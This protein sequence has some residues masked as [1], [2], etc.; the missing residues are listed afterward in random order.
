MAATECRWDVKA[1]MVRPVG[2]S[3][4]A[5]SRD[6]ESR[7]FIASQRLTFERSTDGTSRFER[8]SVLPNGRLDSSLMSQS[9]L[10]MNAFL[11]LFLSFLFY[12][13]T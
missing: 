4:L 10:V 9:A 7:D 11:R 2:C 13:F 6:G 8:I 3:S 1:K 12:L 5:A